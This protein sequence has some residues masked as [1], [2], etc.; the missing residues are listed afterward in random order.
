MKTKLIALSVMTVVLMSGSFSYAQD[1]D[2]DNAIKYRKNIMAAVGGHTKALVAILKGEV[3]HTDA[4]K[5]HADGLVAATE[6]ASVLAAFQQNTDGK[7]SEKTTS[8][9]KIWEEWSRFEQAVNDLAAASKDI[10]TAAANG[11]LSNFDQLK[12]ALKECGFCH[13]DS[14]FR[15]K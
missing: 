9:A 2:P 12:P 7:G 6:P 5:A 1:V 4:L 14:D 3:P 13:R 11:T 10:Q 15:T 8:T